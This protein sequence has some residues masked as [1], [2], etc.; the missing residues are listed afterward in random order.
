MSSIGFRNKMS[1]QY[2]IYKTFCKEHSAK[3]DKDPFEDRYIFPENTPE[4]ILKKANKLY[5][6]YD[7]VK[8]EFECEKSFELKETLADFDDY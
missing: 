5:N 2:D 4:D 3:P 1:E 6:N 7:T 8:H